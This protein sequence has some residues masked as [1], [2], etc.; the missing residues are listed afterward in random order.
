MTDDDFEMFA[1]AWTAAYE[2]CSRGKHCS[3]ASTSLAF[4]A[5]KPYSLDK[6]S[7]ALTRHVR[8]PDNGRFGLTVADVVRQIDGPTMTADQII[9]AAMKP[10]TPLAVLCRIE[11]GSWNLGNFTMQQ[12]KPYAERCIALMP[13]WK[14]RLAKGEIADHER[15]AF[16]RHGVE[17]DN[18]RLLDV[19]RRLA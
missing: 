18:V 1:Q 3:P 7:T 13:E 6:I 12:L 9:G 17:L 15:L 14:A 8:D 19:Q 10:T 5:L 4:E 16:D 11:I 2:L